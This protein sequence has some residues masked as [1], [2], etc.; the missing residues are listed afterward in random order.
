MLP[1]Q[2]DRAVEIICIQGSAPG[3]IVATLS[4]R[5]CVRQIAMTVARHPAG[6][7]QVAQALGG[8]GPRC[9]AVATAVLLE[10]SE[11]FAADE[12]AVAA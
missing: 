1:S 12:L 4:H 10:A 3:R 7:W 2:E 5:T 11:A 8:F 6:G 9:H